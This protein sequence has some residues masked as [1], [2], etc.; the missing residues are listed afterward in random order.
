M[1]EI[2]LKIR[3]FPDSVLRKKCKSVVK[4]T[5]KHRDILSKMSRAMYEGMGIGLA[6]PQIG[7]SEQMIVVDIGSGLYKLINPKIIKKHGS[8]KLSEGCLSIP[9]VCVSVKRAKKI[10]VRALGEDGKP[11]DIEAEDLLACVMQHEMDHL[12]GALIIDHAS[13]LEKLKIKNKLAALRKLSKKND[14]SPGKMVC[15]LEL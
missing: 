6:A 11:L 4:V 7:I 1:N 12:K 14:K 2:A 8:Q 9:G 5:D 15:Q 10:L 13:L 3:L